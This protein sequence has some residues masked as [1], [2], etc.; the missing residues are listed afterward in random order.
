MAR[1]RPEARRRRQAEAGEGGR[2]EAA[3]V[4]RIPAPRKP[5][6]APLDPGRRPLRVARNDCAS[7]DP[8]EAMVCA[9]QRLN[10]RDRQLQQA[11]RNAE[12]AGVPA[13]TLRQQQ[14]RWQQARAAAA[15]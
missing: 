12:A 3:R 4:R 10:A 2:R 8:G 7:Y 1:R 11:Y 15:P 6:D 5:R 9:D 14:M 13:S